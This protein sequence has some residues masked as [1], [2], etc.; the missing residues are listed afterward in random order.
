MVSVG[1]Y[2]FV[3]ASMEEPFV[4]RHVAFAAAPAWFADTPGVAVLIA[5]A[6]LMGALDFVEA[7]HPVGL[8][9]DL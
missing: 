8:A 4:A 1:N 2:V 6:L 3:S 5:L 7:N 9:V